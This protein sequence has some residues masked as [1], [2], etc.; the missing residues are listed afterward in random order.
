MIAAHAKEGDLVKRSKEAT[1]L[2]HAD[3]TNFE[4]L[5]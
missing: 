2:Y 4:T 5:K 3:F 1:I